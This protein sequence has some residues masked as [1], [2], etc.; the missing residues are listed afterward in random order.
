MPR[1]CPRWER[2]ESLALL[3]NIRLGW[4]I[5][6]GTNT[7]AFLASSSEKEEMFYNIIACG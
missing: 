4:K 5:L 2:L 7:Q 3:A 1:V 6:P